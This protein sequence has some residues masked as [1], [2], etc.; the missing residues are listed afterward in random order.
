M[1]ANRL[2][3]GPPGSGKS[4]V[5]EQTAAALE[6][7]GMSVGGI[8][9]PE[10]RTLGHRVG[11][12]IEDLATGETAML[13]HVDRDEGPSVGK[14]RV[15]VAAVDRISEQALGEAAREQVDVML[16]DEIAPMETFSDVFVEA[17]RACL[18]A[19]LPVIGTIHRRG[20]E[21][22]IGEVKQRSDVELIEVSEANRD[23]LPR[24]L[25]EQL[26]GAVEGA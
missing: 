1:P 18:D 14:Y 7:E 10:L 3:T 8:V 16:V 23:E 15:D 12:E 6:D 20:R 26:L 21:G 19:E 2:L 4:T 13:A 17:T 5:L 22:F 11:F 25:T 24:A 9:S